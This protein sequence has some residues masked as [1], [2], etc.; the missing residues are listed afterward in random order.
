MEWVPSF[1]PYAQAAAA[2][3]FYLWPQQQAMWT[4]GP[5]MGSGQPR[6]EMTLLADGGSLFLSPGGEYGGKETVPLFGFVEG[7]MRD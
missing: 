3:K 6:L 2:P 5:G 1:W 7:D 4:M